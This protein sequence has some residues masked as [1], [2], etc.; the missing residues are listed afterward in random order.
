MS[1]HCSIEYFLKVQR[2]KMNQRAIKTGT[3]FRRYPIPKL[4]A[5]EVNS[6]TWV[7]VRKGMKNAMQGHA[8]GPSW[9]WSLRMEPQVSRGGHCCP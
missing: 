3:S 1:Q 8:N 6:E 5:P 9:L 7:K 4:Q 2:V